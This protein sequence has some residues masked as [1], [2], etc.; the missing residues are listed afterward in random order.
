MIC[1][2]ILNKTSINLKKLL[3]TIFEMYKLSNNNAKSY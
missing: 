1:I 3:K 2:E